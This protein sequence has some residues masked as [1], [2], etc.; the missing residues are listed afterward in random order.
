M[1]STTGSFQVCAHPAYRDFLPHMSSAIAAAVNEVA[2]L[3]GVPVRAVQVAQGSLPA[4][5]SGGGTG[6]GQ[7]ASGGVYEFSMNSELFGGPDSTDYQQGFQFDILNAV[8]VG[9]AQAG[10]LKRHRGELVGSQSGSG[11]PAQQAVFYGLLKA[12]G[13]PAAPGAPGG[14]QG[15]GNGESPAQAQ[16]Q[17]EVTAAAA[18]FA[19][20]PAATRHAWLAANLGGLKSGTL[21]LAQIP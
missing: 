13:V 15:Q 9:P 16:Q 10:K 6:Y 5:D 19:A 1:C 18:K 20:L 7:V 3:P 14:Q 17:A 8:I 12:L 4:T 2:G 11:T 21:T